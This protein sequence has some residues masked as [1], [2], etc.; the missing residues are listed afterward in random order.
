MSGCSATGSAAQET[1]AINTWRETTHNTGV[2]SAAEA[3]PD[4][5][6]KQNFE[7][8]TETKGLRPPLIPNSD[9]F[10]AVG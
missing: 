4:N 6:L 10:S 1:A 9:V 8:F 5:V 2:S 3:F 7:R